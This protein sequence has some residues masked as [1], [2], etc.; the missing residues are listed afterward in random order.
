MLQS[1]SPVLQAPAGILCLVSAVA[2]RIAS[3]SPRLQLDSYNGYW[4]SHWRA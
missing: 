2:V 3:L 1:I 4:F